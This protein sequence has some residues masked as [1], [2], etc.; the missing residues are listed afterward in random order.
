[1][2]YDEPQLKAAF[3]RF[4]KLLRELKDE[5]LR[6]VIPFK[7]FIRNFLRVKTNYLDLPTPEIM[8]VLKHEKPNIYLYL[9]KNF[10][11]EPIF[12]FLTH[13]DVD[14]EAARK[15]LDELKESIK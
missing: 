14:Y 10:S 4:D 1:M 3:E 5:D 13:L 9:R 6:N 7:N 8:A 15:K 12:D 2:N 11:Q